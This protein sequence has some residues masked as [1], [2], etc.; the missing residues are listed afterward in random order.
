MAGVNLK[1]H[2]HQYS[3]GWK[4]D[5]VKE[6]VTLC[7]QLQLPLHFQSSWSPSQILRLTW[8]SLRRVGWGT[9]LLTGQ[10]NWLKE[11]W[12]SHGKGNVL[13]PL[14]K[15]YGEVQKL[16]KVFGNVLKRGE[17]VHQAHGMWHIK[18]THI[19]ISIYPILGHWPGM[20]WPPARGVENFQTGLQL[21]W[22]LPIRA[23]SIQMCPPIWWGHPPLIDVHGLLWWDTGPPCAQTCYSCC[24]AFHL[25]APFSLSLSLLGFNLSLPKIT[26]T[27]CIHTGAWENNAD[28]DDWCQWHR[29]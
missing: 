21:Y 18:I 29:R 19:V 26:F 4:Q 5:C 16:S 17:D 28:N 2:C 9:W 13:I 12:V 6:R 22:R 15:C 27:G 25:L 8:K 11:T 23:H 7:L 1:G 20:A 14:S 10:L 3:L 24:G